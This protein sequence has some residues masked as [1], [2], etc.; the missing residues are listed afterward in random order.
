MNQEIFNTALLNTTRRAEALARHQGVTD[1][2]S[3]DK[4]KDAVRDT[5]LVKRIDALLY[6]NPIVAD[7]L[8]RITQDQIT[9]PETAIAIPAAMIAR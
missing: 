2:G 5:L 7:Q 1:P 3:I 4:I 6:S 9:N 8:F